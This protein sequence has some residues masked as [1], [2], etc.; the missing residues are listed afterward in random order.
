MWE[1][2]VVVCDGR[3]FGW[4]WEVCRSCSHGH[5]YAILQTIPRL[6]RRAR[7]LD[8]LNPIQTQ[9]II[10]APTVSPPRRPLQKLLIL[11]PALILKIQV[12]HRP[13]INIL[14]TTTTPLPEHP[15]QHTLI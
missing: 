1:E 5:L 13:I 4:G 9:I 3:V 6:L 11:L 8:L 14:S 10:T 15:H 7:P 2:L 12:L